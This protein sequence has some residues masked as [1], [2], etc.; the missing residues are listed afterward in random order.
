M[1]E[2]VLEEREQAITGAPPVVPL[3][4]ADGDVEVFEEEGMERAAGGCA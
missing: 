2:A 4:H 1:A 3:L